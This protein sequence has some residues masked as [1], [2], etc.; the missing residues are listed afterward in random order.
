MPGRIKQLAVRCFRLPVVAERQFF[1][2]Y[3]SPGEFRSPFFHQAIVRDDAVQPR[4]ELGTVIELIELAVNIYK[5]ILQG[6]GCFFPVAAYLESKTV[7][8]ILVRSY[9][10]RECL[11]VSVACILQE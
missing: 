4:C 2:R 7:N 1:E 5:G 3:G 10:R 6:L 8:K 9:N 11:M